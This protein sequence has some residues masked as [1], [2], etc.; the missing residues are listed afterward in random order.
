MPIIATSSWME[1]LSYYLQNF[2]NKR[3]LDLTIPG[4]HDAATYTLTHSCSSAFAVTQTKTLKDQFHLGVR[5]F[6]IRIK[7]Q[8]E[9]KASF[10][11]TTTH[12]KLKYGF[13][14]TDRLQYFHGLVK[15]QKDDGLEGMRRFLAAVTA[16]SE[17]VILKLDFGSFGDFSQFSEL[18]LNGPINEHIFSGGDLQTQTIGQ[19]QANNK[20][21]ILLTKGFAS[22]ISSDY[23]ENSFG[24]WAK[25]RKPEKLASVMNNIR[26]RVGTADA[27]KIKVVQTN[28]PA[29]VG[30]GGNRFTSVLE[31]D[32]KPESRTITEKFVSEARNDLI[33]AF[34]S[35]NAIAVRLVSQAV[36][37][38][39]SL[40]NIGSDENKNQLIHRIIELNLGELLLTCVNVDKPSDRKVEHQES[41]KWCYKFVI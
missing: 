9:T 26:N 40:D 34:K 20:N 39:I 17:V 8:R 36:R 19:M 6:D 4:S 35:G 31:Q 38:V 16:S 18:Y 11:R 30:S 10:Y 14:P 7:R 41:Q 12:N 25:T 32:K 15:S 3:V 33:T 22:D 2:R 29:L 5:Y 37:G 13:A 28:Q 27:N 24:K 23:K 1:D 21:I